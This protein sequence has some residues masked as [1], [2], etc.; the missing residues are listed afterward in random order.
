M[1][2]MAT[3]HILW[4]YRNI[5]S[6]FDDTNIRNQLHGEKTILARWKSHH[7]RSR[8]PK[9]MYL[10]SM[11][12]ESL[13]SGKI[14]WWSKS[15]SVLKYLLPLHISM[16]WHIDSDEHG[17]CWWPSSQVCWPPH[18]QHWS[19]YGLRWWSSSQVSWSP[20]LVTISERVFWGHSLYWWC[21]FSISGS[22]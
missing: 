5:F 4:C 16:I 13:L 11:T 7:R 21:E 15:C 17:L 3:C 1:V 22:L 14:D 18:H 9:T 2:C 10:G 6:V 8:H 20:T 12:G 19:P